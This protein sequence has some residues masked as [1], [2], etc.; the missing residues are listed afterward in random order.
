MHP[1]RL[2][3]SSAWSRVVDSMS[4][5]LDQGPTH[6]RTILTIAA[7]ALLLYILIRLN[8]KLAHAIL[9]DSKR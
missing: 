2:I 7:A 8:L 9:R 6:T 1:P 5:A 4:A 3:A